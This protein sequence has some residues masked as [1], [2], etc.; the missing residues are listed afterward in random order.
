QAEALAAQP[1]CLAAVAKRSWETKVFLKV[2]AQFL[3]ATCKTGD[4]IANVG[5]DGRTGLKRKHS[6]KR[7][8][9]VN[10]GR[11]YI[12]PEG[13]IVDRAGTDPAD[14]ALNRVQSRQQA[15]PFAGGADR[16]PRVARH[17]AFAALP[18]RVGWA[19]HGINGS[20]FFTCRLRAGEMKVQ[21]VSWGI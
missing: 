1:G 8:D 6:I 4:V 15:V 16:N 19:Q 20:T 7:R 12:Q 18:A 21:S 13:R 17:F 5:H 2:A 10:F 14:S 11:G 3:R 9:A